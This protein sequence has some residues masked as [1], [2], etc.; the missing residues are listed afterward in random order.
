VNRAIEITSVAY[1]VAPNN[2][3]KP[4]ALD[5]PT[6][7]KGAKT[8][9]IDCLISNRTA[10]W[11]TVSIRAELAGKIE[12]FS[13]PDQ[14]V[15]LSL[16]PGENLCTRTLTVLAMD[17]DHA[18]LRVQA[19]SIG[20]E[21]LLNEWKSNPIRI[22]G[23][24]AIWRTLLPLYLDQAK[25]WDEKRLTDEIA[26]RSHQLRC[27]HKLQ[28]VNARVSEMEGKFLYDLIAGLKRLK[29]SPPTEEI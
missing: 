10:G 3:P 24:L 1:A 17:S 5:S 22:V 14:D 29:P 19:W 28:H 18:T 11:L 15:V 23:M 12:R 27:V 4:A 2:C 25:S 13:R 9:W 26:R 21:V 6:K 20:E 16:Q 8:L 7:I